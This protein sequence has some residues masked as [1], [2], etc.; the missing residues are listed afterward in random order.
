MAGECKKKVM[1][2]KI[3]LKKSGRGVLY[4]SQVLLSQPKL[5]LLI[6]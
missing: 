5:D 3:N 2:Q 1:S 4:D 6:T